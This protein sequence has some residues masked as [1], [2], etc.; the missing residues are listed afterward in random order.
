[1]QDIALVALVSSRLCHDLIGPT[2]AVVNGLELIASEPELGAEALRMVSQ[3]AEQISVR[4]QFYRSAYGVATGLTFRA[5]QDLAQTF[6]QG[7][8]VTLTWSADPKALDAALPKGVAKLALNLLLLGA[9]MLGKGGTL[10]VGYVAQPRPTIAVRVVGDALRQDLDLPGQPG[11]VPSEDISPRTVQPI[12]VGR[13]AEDLACCGEVCR[14]GG[15]GW[16]PRR[17]YSLCPS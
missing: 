13:L 9:D 2:S 11:A 1:M 5:A 15:S 17:A 12:L 10:E 3:S 6:F 14:P 16:R 7:G 8:R 4:L